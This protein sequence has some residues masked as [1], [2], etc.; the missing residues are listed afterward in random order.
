MVKLKIETQV[1]R[2]KSTHTVGNND[3]LEPTP[4]S[5]RSTYRE[6]C[7]AIDIKVTKNGNKITEESL[8]FNSKNHILKNMRS[9]Y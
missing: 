3:D 9:A 6:C 8:P 4:N 1:I 2:K 7:D 5:Y